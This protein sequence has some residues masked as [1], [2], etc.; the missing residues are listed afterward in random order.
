MKR[1]FLSFRDPQA[2]PVPLDLRLVG[3]SLAEVI[4]KILLRTAAATRNVKSH[5]KKNARE[6]ILNSHIRNITSMR[7]ITLNA[8]KKYDVCHGQKS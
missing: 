6:Y 3:D 7:Y 4:F 8:W 2:R 5:G 1:V